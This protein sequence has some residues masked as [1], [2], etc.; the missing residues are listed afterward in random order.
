MSSKQHRDKP[1]LHARTDLG[2]GPGEEARHSAGARPAA[3]AAVEMASAMEAS[4]YRSDSWCLGIRV[5]LYV[6]MDVAKVLRT[7]KANSFSAGGRIQI[8]LKEGRLFFS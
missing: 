7:S 5:K 1:L 8:R 3:A 2:S 4:S 6:W